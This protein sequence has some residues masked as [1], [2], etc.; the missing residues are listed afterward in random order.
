MSTM[1]SDQQKDLCIT[2]LEAFED[3]FLFACPIVIDKRG[4]CPRPMHACRELLRFFLLG[5]AFC[6][7]LSALC[8]QEQIIR[9]T[10]HVGLSICQVLRIRTELDFF[11]FWRSM[12]LVPN[13]RD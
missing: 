2:D 3:T 10:L 13:I 6:C 8:P 12:D 7:L 9:I 4:W 5:V 1:S 11:F